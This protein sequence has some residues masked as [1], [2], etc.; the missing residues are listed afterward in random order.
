MKLKYDPLP[1]VLETGKH[2]HKVQIL[3]ALGKKETSLYDRSLAALKAQQNPD[4]GWSWDYKEN[5]PSA[6]ANS[7]RT[8]FTLLETGDYDAEPVEKAVEFLYSMQRQDGGWS[9][10]PVLEP[11][12]QDNWPWFSAVH[13]VTWITGRVISTL[14]KAGCTVDER[15]QKGVHFLENMQNEEGGW[16]SH[17]GS[18]PDTKMWNMEEVVSAFISTGRKDTDT[19]KRAIEATYAHTERWPEPVESPLS[20]FCQLGYS[21]DHP[22]VRKCIDYFV[23]NQHKDGG[24]GYYNN[25][26]SDPTQTAAWTNV[27]VKCN[28][29][30]PDRSG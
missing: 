2:Y 7:A 11:Q 16:P 19:V 6:V 15:I 26:P 23:K 4:G 13:S 8:L 12:I 25:S 17:T 1:F 14:V 5:Q 24:W 28:V 22:I 20:M 27:L 18:P 30:V 10:N 3:N 21:L 9:E 29:D